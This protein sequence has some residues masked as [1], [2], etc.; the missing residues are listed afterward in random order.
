MCGIA[1]I[2]KLNA[3]TTPDDVAAV[4]RM[5][6]AQ[7]HRGPDGTIPWEDRLGAK[8]D[9]RRGGSERTVCYVAGFTAEMRT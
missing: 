8:E 3:L 9:L 1:G 7:V 6:D 5:N 2:L 4:Q